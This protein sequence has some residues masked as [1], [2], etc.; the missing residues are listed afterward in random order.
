MLIRE[1]A[2]QLFNE[3]SE[4]FKRILEVAKNGSLVGIK[5]RLNFIDS[6]TATWT[7]SDNPSG[8]SVDISINSSG[9]G[10]ISDGDKGDITVSGTGTIWT[11]DPNT[12]DNT[13]IRDSIGASVIGRAVNSFGDPA[14]IQAVSDGDV[15]HRS[16]GSLVFGAIPESSVTNLVSDLAGKVPTSRTISSS[17]PITGGGDLSANRTIGFDGA[18]DLSN[19]ARVGVRVAGV[20]IASRRHVNFINLGGVTITGTDDPANE[21]VEVSLLSTAAS[22]AVYSA[23][24]DVPYVVNEYNSQISNAS[25][26]T[27]SNILV[28]LDK[29]T[30][31]DTNEGDILFWVTDVKTGSF[32]LTVRAKEDASLI[33]GPFNFKYLIL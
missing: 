27:S 28:F 3:I 25:I 11:I 17:S 9:G 13:K 21:E 30:Y 16:A 7:V 22:P 5:T 18:V 26:L 15:L 33:G 29:I 8:K 4:K 23:T 1:D 32:N 12:V 14:D 31:S 2:R 20:D 24:V 19:K 6:S 10:G